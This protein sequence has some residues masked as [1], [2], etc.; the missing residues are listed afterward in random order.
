MRAYEVES[1]SALHAEVLRNH[2]MKGLFEKISKKILNFEGAHDRDTK[3]HPH[4]AV[5]RRDES[6]QNIFGY[7]RVLKSEDFIRMYARTQNGRASCCDLEDAM[8]PFIQT[9]GYFNMRVQDWEGAERALIL[10][11]RACRER[12]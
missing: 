8:D 3:A 10:M 4:Y 6:S 1:S 5:Y 7:V 9:T 12:F 11:E 2:P